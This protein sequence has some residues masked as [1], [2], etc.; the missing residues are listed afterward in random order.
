MEALKKFG[1]DFINA[2]T[3]EKGGHSLRKL[4]AVG[5]FWVMTVVTFKYTSEA[6]IEV[7]LGIYSALITALVITYTAGN[8]KQM[9]KDEV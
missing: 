6:N 5:C 8:I 4:L 2:L 1:T 7:V 9:K 3:N